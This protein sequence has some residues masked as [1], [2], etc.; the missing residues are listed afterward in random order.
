MDE[1]L[2]MPDG[3]EENSALD[4]S[5]EPED[6]T[7]QLLRWWDRFWARV[8]KLGMGDIALRTGSALV[9]IGLVGLV[10]WVMKGFFMPSEMIRSEVEP[11]ELAAAEGQG[12][13]P[14]YEGVAPVAGLSK[15]ADT[16]TKA[17]TVA[18]DRNEFTPYIVQA[19]DSLYTIAERF[20]LKPPSILYTNYSVLQDNPAFILPGQELSI[21][22]VDGVLW[23]WTQGNGLNKF[24]ETFSVTPDVIINWPGNNLS[25]DTIGDYVNPNIEDGQM[26]FVPGGK[27]EYIDWAAALFGRETTGTSPVW[28]AGKCDVSANL[29]PDGTGTYTWPTILYGLG[30]GGYDWDPEGGHYGVDL[31]GGR[32]TPIYAVDS[33]IPLFVGFSEWGYGNVIVLDHGS[34]GIQTIYAHLDSFNIS[35]GSFVTKGDVIGTL[36]NTGNSSGP[37][38]HFEIRQGSIR[39]NPYNYIF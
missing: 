19:G 30:G 38:L 34:T 27:R 17:G 14:A 28:G 29:G 16:E 23:P 33:G 32:G 24:A 26:I 36:G 3:R 9:T 7:A 20:G 4:N 35:C 31:G 39:L 11:L 22:P 1:R 10:I 8:T 15:S 18:A 5:P 25:P 2:M 12:L 13:L 21:P 37:H 6:G